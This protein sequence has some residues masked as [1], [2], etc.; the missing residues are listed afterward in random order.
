MKR[1]PV[2]STCLLLAALYALS[3]CALLGLQKGATPA[4]KV[5]ALAK[6]MTAANDVFAT[7][8]A[9]GTIKDPKVI[10]GYNAA[11]SE[12]NLSIHT[13]ND[14]AV[15][16]NSAAFDDLYPK[17]AGQLV[18][19]SLRYGLHKTPTVPATTQ[20]ATKPVAM[21]SGG[22][23][24]CDVMPNE[25]RIERSAGH[26]SHPICR[27]SVCCP[28]ENLAKGRN[29]PFL[30]VQECNATNARNAFLVNFGIV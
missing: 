18:E 10:A 3:G 14:Y 19:L 27:S 6:D 30:A 11:Q 25:R 21:R 4:Q 29:V 2:A 22:S 1:I 26:N 7:L 16:G 24:L 23:L 8:V 9:D 20:P 13:L 17:I 5:S 12:I 28:G 15:S